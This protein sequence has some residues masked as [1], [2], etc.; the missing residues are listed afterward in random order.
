MYQGVNQS[1]NFYE[2]SLLYV[3]LVCKWNFGFLWF[4]KPFQRQDERFCLPKGG[5]GLYIAGEISRI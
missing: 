5:A 1:V 3:D 4:L 2:Y